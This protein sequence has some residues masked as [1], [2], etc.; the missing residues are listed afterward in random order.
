[1]KV[2][3]I[4]QASNKAEEQNKVFFLNQENVIVKQIES[5]KL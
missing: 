1:M 5:I 3:I 4:E 2:Q